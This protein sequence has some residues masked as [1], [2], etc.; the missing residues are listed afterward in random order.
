MLNV[1]EH[2]VQRYTKFLSAVDVGETRG[3]GDYCVRDERLSMVTRISHAYWDVDASA[4]GNPFQDVVVG[5]FGSCA[6][7]GLDARSPAAS[8]HVRDVLAT[9]A[10]VT[11]AE[12]IEPGHETRVLDHERHQ[13]RRVASDAEEL[14]AVLLYEALEDRV[15]S[16]P[17]AMAIGFF[18][19]LPQR[20]E[21]LNVPSGSD[22]MYDHIEGRRWPLTRRASERR[23]YIRWWRCRAVSLLVELFA[24]RRDKD[25]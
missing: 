21:R 23:R 1:R 14:Q 5:R 20:Q 25:L 8:D 2:H 15:C 12:C 13:L 7:A 17:D 9:L 24:E 6:I 22:D 4:A 19:D 18:E 11:A 3:I 16:E 10:D